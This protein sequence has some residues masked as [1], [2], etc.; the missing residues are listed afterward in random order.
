MSLLKKLYIIRRSSSICYSISV[1]TFKPTW[2][3]SPESALFLIIFTLKMS[4]VAD[5][6]NYCG[7]VLMQTDTPS[8]CIHS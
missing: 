7:L 8:L 3:R 6:L 4:N 5:S 1:T 2:L